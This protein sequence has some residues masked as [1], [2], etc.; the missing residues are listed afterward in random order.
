MAP[1]A[2]VTHKNKLGVFM[3]AV[4]VVDPASAYWRSVVYVQSTFPSGATFA[5][6]GVMVG[7]NDV[8]TASH[9]LYLASQGGAATSVTVVP[10]F[11]A[12][13][14]SK[15]YGE[16]VSTS[17][18]Y[19]AN[20]DPTGSG[21][22]TQ[23]DGGAGLAGSELDIGL[24]DLSTAV[25][26]QTGWM[27]LDP[28]FTGGT[29]NVTGFPAYYGWDMVNSTVYAYQPG[30]DSIVMLPDA[31]LHPGNSGGPV[32]YVSGGEAYV[33][34]V[35]STALWGA[36]VQGTYAQLA[37]WIAANDPVTGG[38]SPIVVV[39]QD[40]FSGSA[41]N[42]RF[43]A[44]AGSDTIDGGGGFD[45]AAYTGKLSDYAIAR[46]DGHWTIS[47]PATGTDTLYGVEKLTFADGTVKILA[48]TARASGADFDGDGRGDLLWQND[49]GRPAIWEM[50]G[51]AT[52]SADLVNH[53]V[54]VPASWTIAG[55]GDF[56]GDGRG[57]I[58]WRNDD[59]RAAVWQM[60]GL[61]TQATDLID[62]G[63][64]VPAEWSIAGTGDF[65]G[66]G[67]DDVLW[68]SNGGD[69]SVWLM[70]GASTTQTGLVDPGLDTPSAWRVAGVD[71]FNGD[72]R[73]D[74]LWRHDDGH[75][76]L[77]LMNGMSASVAPVNQGI[78]TPTDWNVAGTGDFNADGRADILWRADDGRVALWL[79]DGGSVLLADVLAGGANIPQSW[80]IAGT[81]DFDGD[82]REDIA[83]RSDAGEPSV[84]AM[85]GLSI[86]AAD[87]V[88][89]GV[90]VPNDWFIA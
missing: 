63:V 85:N 77:S 13:P 59:G 18:H 8:L 58:L 32:W 88:N 71:D 48:S 22:L 51:V 38:T 31:D 55:S 30:P 74:V 79:M 60:N 34:G 2:G 10:A 75:L 42:D 65:N 69:T 28:G 90:Q 66:D 53:G 89:G 54:S 40:P 64:V 35:V 47:G 5:A 76:S 20:Y 84:W 41:A 61:A 1:G 36:D 78:V 16:L 52:R 57:D 70:N 4:E 83:W 62:S 27:Q 80:Q 11:D 29:V 82:G 81:G 56:N 44:T 24:I 23:G 25:G 14:Y 7:P 87:L 67:R 86:H 26:N 72:G 46:T 68:R 45:I 73:A 15:P 43:A 19:F 6:S 12:S 21:L 37:Q 3:S 50:S 17:F 9:V 49:D 33:V 39:P